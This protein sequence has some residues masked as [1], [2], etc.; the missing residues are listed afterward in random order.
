MKVLVAIF[1]LSLTLW[2][3]G[4]SGWPT[5]VGRNDFLAL[6]IAAAVD[7]LSPSSASSSRA[8][9]RRLALRERPENLSR[10]N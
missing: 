3:R 8:S 7:L 9:F 5:F 2:N 10:F 1:R 4:D 6:R